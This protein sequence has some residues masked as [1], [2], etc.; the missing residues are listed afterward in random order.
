VIRKMDTE[1]E[2]ETLSLSECL[3]VALNQQLLDTNENKAV[4]SKS[5]FDKVSL[6]N[7][8]LEINESMAH[9]ECYE[10]KLTVQKE[11]LEVKTQV[12]LENTKYN[13]VRIKPNS[14][15]IRVRSA[16][17]S[18]DME[19]NLFG[20]DNSLKA[21]HQNTV[22]SC[23]KMDIDDEDSG[24][25]RRQRVVYECLKK[26]ND[27]V[28]H[29]L[30]ATKSK[31]EKYSMRRKSLDKRHSRSTTTIVK[32]SKTEKTSKRLSLLGR[33][34]FCRMPEGG[35]MIGCDFCD[36]WYHTDC[37][38][39]KQSRIIELSKQTWACPK[40]E[41]EKASSNTSKQLQKLH[42]SKEQ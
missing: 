42:K 16:N 10:E 3:E 7:E 37:L 19:T 12:S 6:I 18:Y 23:N 8:K 14:K 17:D 24:R 28:K 39:L 34:C 41:A 26:R 40:C 30:N 25:P 4:T 29:S 36:E 20:F 13:D 11:S 35:N 38:N 31:N 5:V 22:T 1:V 2:Q 33:F 9:P 21:V 15:D 27:D 32:E